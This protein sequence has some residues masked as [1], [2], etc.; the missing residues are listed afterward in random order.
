MVFSRS[1]RVV[2]DSAEHR[3]HRYRFGFVCDVEMELTSSS[4]M[5]HTVDYMLRN[6]I[7]I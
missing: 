1:T 5:L 7:Y 4:I 2:H 6:T 3:R